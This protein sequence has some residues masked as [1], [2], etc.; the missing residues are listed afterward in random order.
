MTCVLFLYTIGMGLIVCDMYSYGTN[1]YFNLNNPSQINWRPEVTVRGHTFDF[2]QTARILSNYGVNLN[3]DW[4][5]ADISKIFQRTSQ[6][7]PFVPPSSTCSVPNR[8]P[9]SPPLMATNGSCLDINILNSIGS[10]GKIIFNWDDL[11]AHASEPNIFMGYS[12]HLVNLT[13]YIRGDD[14]SFFLNRIPGNVRQMLIN[15]VGRDA[16]LSF[17]STP[18]SLAAV[19]CLIERYNVGYIGAQSVGCTVK[20]IFMTL[21]ITIIWTVILIKVIMAITFQ[22]I[23]SRTLTKKKSHPKPEKGVSVSI[24][25]HDDN[26][27]ILITCYSEG[28][29]G[30]RSTLNSVASAEYPGKKK[31]IFVVADGLITGT[32]NKTSTPDLLINMIQ[33][34]PGLETAPKSYIAIAE[35][36]RQQNMASVVFLLLWFNE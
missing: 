36:A 4:Q 11:Q 16:T 12:N 14:S 8:L 35:G 30:L 20:T 19:R 10:S 28:E 18:A 3:S 21:V 6:C 34:N 26:V 24:K 5:G 27:I 33:L 1:S 22:C 2:N 31:L 9:M 29:K 17:S 32:G 25:G 15:G 13:D 23:C 7:Q